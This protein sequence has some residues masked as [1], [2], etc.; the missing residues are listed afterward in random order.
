[1]SASRIRVSRL[2]GLCDPFECSPWLCMGEITR[3][4]VTQC[5]T[6]DDLRDA[7]FGMDLE[8]QVD[9]TPADHARRIAWLVRNGWSDAILVDLGVPGWTDPAH[10]PI[11]DGN[12]RFAAAIFRGDLH[13]AAEVSGAVDQIRKLLG[14]A[15]ARV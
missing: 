1:M 14:K 11:E 7:P 5:L 6:Q 2:Q 10:W 3:E 15:A 12:H 8:T 9:L 4:L 13:I